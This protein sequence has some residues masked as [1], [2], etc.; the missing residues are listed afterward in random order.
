MLFVLILFLCTFSF[1]R[2]DDQELILL[3]KVI[4]LDP[5]HGT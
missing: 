5:G 1:A 3:G 2:A 4:Y